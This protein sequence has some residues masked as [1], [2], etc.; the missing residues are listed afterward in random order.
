M[1]HIIAC[2]KSGIKD[3]PS[4]LGAETL[5]ELVNN[6]YRCVYGGNLDS[7]LKKLKMNSICDSPLEV[8]HPVFNGGDPFH[9]R[10]HIVFKWGGCLC[11]NSVGWSSVMWWSCVL[12]S[13]QMILWIDLVC[14][15]PLW[16]SSV[17]ILCWYH[18][19][20]LCGDLMS[21]MILCCI[22][23]CDNP[24]IVYLC[25]LILCVV[26]FYV[27]ILCVI[28][29]CWMILCGMVMCV[30]MCLVILCVITLW[31]MILCVIFLCV[32]YDPV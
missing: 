31:V 2:R 24:L 1:G 28:I 18:A 26:I 23:F 11:L 12:I 4:F 27:V 9:Q 16:W 19:M 22:P 7:F 30:I 3:K 10:D 15:D 25:A 32:C 5:A 29:L 17:V 13:S 21:V 20:I 8:C 14:H 6:W